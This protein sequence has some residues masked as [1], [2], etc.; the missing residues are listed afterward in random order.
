LNTF[1]N[2]TEKELDI[3]KIFWE[4][5]KPVTIQE[6]LSE[7]DSKANDTTIHANLRKLMKK[8]LIEATGK[9]IVTR[10]PARFY[11]RKL[12]IEEY[13]ANQILSVYSLNNNFDILKLL[14]VLY[15]NEALNL[16]IND[17]ETFLREVSV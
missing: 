10:T 11:F 9:T 17:V 7:Y 12:S 1:I 3:M 15:S 5:E 13:L 16:S 14:T 6:F 8:G 4:L 2:L